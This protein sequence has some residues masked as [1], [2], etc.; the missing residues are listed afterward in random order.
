MYAGPAH[1]SEQVMVRD[2]VLEVDGMS[3]T[4]QNIAER[5]VGE[6]ILTFATFDSSE[7]QCFAMYCSV[8]QRVNMCCRVL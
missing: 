5:I 2:E 3:V 6:G 1:L 8:L 4:E 7:L